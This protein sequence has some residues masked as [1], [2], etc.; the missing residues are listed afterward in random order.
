LGSRTGTTRAEALRAWRREEDIADASGAVPKLPE[1]RARLRVQNPDLF[2]INRTLFDRPLRQR[3]IPPVALG[4]GC[5]VS[6]AANRIRPV[7]RCWS[8]RAAQEASAAVLEAFSL[9]ADGSP[10]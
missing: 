6:A 8:V 4:R 9:K 10:E 2:E 1:I 3:E 7:R 5:G